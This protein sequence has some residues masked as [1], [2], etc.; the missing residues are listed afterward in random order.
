MWIDTH[1]HFDFPVFDDH[2]QSDWEIAQSQGVIAQFV[3]GVTPSHFDRL[4]QTANH[5]TGVYFALGIHPYFIN[6]LNVD[7]DTAITTLKNAIDSNLSHPRFIGIGEIGLD[8]HFQ[9]IDF[10]LQINYFNAQL[11]VA[12]DYD[13]PVFIHLRKAQDQVLKY[14]RQAGLQRGIAHAFSGSLQQAEQYLQRGLKLGFGGAVTY[15]RASRLQRLAATLPLDSFVLETDA[16]DMPP[17]WINTKTNYSYHLPR[18]AE[19]FAELRGVSLPVLSQQLINNTATIVPA[20]NH[21]VSK[22]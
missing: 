6:T 7:L 11:R 2:R 10:S 15:P 4:K 8:G 17:A 1:T 22:D 13:L 20:I 21:V 19:Y 16:P 18:I 3:M 9:N 14:Y 12:R 5:F